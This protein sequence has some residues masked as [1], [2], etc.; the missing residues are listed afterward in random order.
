MDQYL[1]KLLNKQI[2]QFRN[3]VTEYDCSSEEVL[4]LKSEILSTRKQLGNK[5]SNKAFALKLG[6]LALVFGFG[7]YTQAQTFKPGVELYSGEGLIIPSVITDVDGDDKL[8]LVGNI[9]F[10]WSND[11]YLLNSSTEVLPEVDEN[12]TNPI[13]LEDP[14][15]EGKVSYIDLDNDGDLDAMY[16]TYN[17]EGEANIH[18]QENLSGNSS[19]DFS[20]GPQVNPFGLSNLE[21]YSDIHLFD[22][23]GDGDFDLLA[24][25]YYSNIFIYPNT[26]SKEE[27]AFGAR[28]LFKN[29]GEEVT[30]FI[31]SGD[32]DND[33]D[34][35]LLIGSYSY[36]NE[37]YEISVSN[38]YFQNN[39][40]DFEESDIPFEAPTGLNLGL[41]CTGDFDAD[42]DMDVV[43]S[44]YEYNGDLS[45]LFYE[46]T[47]ITSVKEIQSE[48]SLYPNPT[49]NILNWKTSEDIISVRILSISGA[50]VLSES[51][52]NNS[53]QIDHL[54]PGTY[55][56][57]FRNSE[58]ETLNKR[59]QK[60]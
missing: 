31:S 4:E 59:I 44:N 15:I 48:I 39:N 47:T 30:V 22:V 8:D 1:H 2:K 13:N 19:F 57:E 52:Q 60:I 25:D 50:E 49:S 43:Y 45:I 14:D 5:I 55:L 51:V 17:Y 41:M 11:S 7:L 12:D 53:I 46:N 16:P 33:G 56:I 26:G 36:D 58:G 40:G 37:T 34:S 23:D 54:K 42:G 28:E 27:C 29:L 10:E 24:A 38:T 18:F 3:S 9:L 20:E 35:D 6:S 21:D 32:L